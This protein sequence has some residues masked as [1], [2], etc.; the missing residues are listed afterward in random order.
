MTVSKSYDPEQ[1]NKL[2]LDI[3][4]T[5]ISNLVHLHFQVKCL[6][7]RLRYQKIAQQYFA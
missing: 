4:K 2:K 7:S 1:N 6:H 3:Q 5:S